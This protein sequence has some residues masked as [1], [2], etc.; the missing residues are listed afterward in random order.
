MAKID[1]E[2]TVCSNALSLAEL[3]EELQLLK[4]K[5]VIGLFW[6]VSLLHLL[7]ASKLRV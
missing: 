4:I 3:P 2:E 7:I 6:R 5:S 1:L